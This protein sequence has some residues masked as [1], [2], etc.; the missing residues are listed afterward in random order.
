MIKTILLN[1]GDRTK[2]PR[3]AVILN[4]INFYEKLY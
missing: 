2:M 3:Y 1:N 4:N